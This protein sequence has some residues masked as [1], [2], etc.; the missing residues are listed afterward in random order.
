MWRGKNAWKAT[1]KTERLVLYT[2]RYKHTHATKLGVSTI[3]SSVG[4]VSILEEGVPPVWKL[5]AMPIE[6]F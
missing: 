6:G 5:I 2:S 1:A 3:T 4:V